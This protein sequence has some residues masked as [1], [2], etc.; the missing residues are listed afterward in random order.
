MVNHERHHSLQLP[1]RPPTR[2]CEPVDA[3]GITR[4][5]AWP[6]RIN[7]FLW[8][9]HADQL[10][11]ARDICTNTRGRGPAFAQAFDTYT[12]AGLQRRSYG[13]IACT[14]VAADCALVAQPA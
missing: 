1:P 3:A 8:L 10:A 13:R 2:S 9:G 4:V 5:C 6:D 14:G 11:V 7:I 12:S